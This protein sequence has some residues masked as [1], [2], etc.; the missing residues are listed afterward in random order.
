MWKWDKK[1][2]ERLMSKEYQLKFFFFY[3]VGSLIGSIIMV[4]ITQGRF[5]LIDLLHKFIPFALGGIIG[6]ILMYFLSKDRRF[7]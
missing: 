7:M 3:M 4:F 6:L 1:A 2:R 5:T